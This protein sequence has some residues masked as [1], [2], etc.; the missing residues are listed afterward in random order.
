MKGERPAGGPADERDGV[1]E[2]TGFEPAR[3]WLRDPSGLGNRCN[4]PLCHLSI[5]RSG[6]RRR[7][8]AFSLPKYT[9][10]VGCRKAISRAP[11]IFPPRAYILTIPRWMPFRVYFLRRR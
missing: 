7:V 8:A 9:R 5:A 4:R 3:A 10:V 2:R 1:E 6:R 11:K